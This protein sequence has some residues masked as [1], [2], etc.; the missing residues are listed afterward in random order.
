[1]AEAARTDLEDVQ[2]LG[3][4]ALMDLHR[5]AGRPGYR[6]PENDE[7]PCRCELCI[8]VGS[9]AAASILARDLGAL[10]PITVDRDRLASA[11]TYHAHQGGCCDG[12]RPG[13]SLSEH[14]IDVALGEGDVVPERYR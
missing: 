4:T 9:F 10:G 5:L 12:V 8:V 1:M 2:H 7:A 14:A 11:I 6:V 13:E 3:Q